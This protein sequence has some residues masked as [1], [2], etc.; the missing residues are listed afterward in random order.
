MKKLTMLV[1]FAGM[2]YGCGEVLELIPSDGITAP[3]KNPDAGMA[4]VLDSI[5]ECYANVK[6]IH[7]ALTT[8]VVL[9]GWNNSV[10]PV[11]AIRV[12]DGNGFA[13]T[14]WSNEQGSFYI[15]MPNDNVVRGDKMFVTVNGVSCLVKK[16]EV[17]LLL[18]EEINNNPSEEIANCWAKEKLIEAR[19][20]GKEVVVFGRR[21]S[22]EY[23]AHVTAADKKGYSVRVESSGQGEFFAVLPLNQYT[24][25]GQEVYVVVS[26]TKCLSTVK[27]TVW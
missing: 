26:S 10:A 11:T 13:K 5:S 6:D 27:V 19:Y 23:N 17:E 16:I 18:P 12:D 15:V 3:A 7:A 1:I 21:D 24:Q 25:A 9:Y 2:P 8:T 22:V 4:L 14:V 20:N